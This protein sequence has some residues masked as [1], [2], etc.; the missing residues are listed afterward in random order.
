M[1][2]KMD[3]YE[4]LEQIGKGA[5]GSAI[6]VYHKQERKKYVLKKIRLARQTDRCRRSAHQEMALISKVRHPFII[7]YKESWVEKGCHVCIVTTYCE[8]GDMSEFIKKANGVYFS[9]DRL[10]TWFAQILLAVDY[11]HTNHIL[12]RDLKCSNIFLSK[13]H[14][15]R[16]GDFG[17]A[18]MLKADDLA[19]SVVGTPT[20]MCPELLADIPYGFKS[21][22]WS[23]GCCLFEMAAHKPAFKAFDMQGLV[24]KVNK[25]MIGPLPSMYSGTFKNLVKTMLRKNP[26]HRPTASELLKNPHV[27]PYVAKCRLQ[28]GLILAETPERALRNF[29][30]DDEIIDISHDTSLFSSDRESY[31]ASVK[32]SLKK[33]HDYGDAKVTILRRENIEDNNGSDSQ[34]WHLSDVEAP[35]TAAYVPT[36]GAPN[37]KANAA[38]WMED[39]DSYYAA[40]NRRKLA[41]NPMNNKGAGIGKINVKPSQAT[42]SRAQKGS[43]VTTPRTPETAGAYR[44]RSDSSK[45]V[46]QDHTSNYQL[47][48]QSPRIRIQSK[49]LHED[50]EDSTILAKHKSSIPSTPTSRRAA[51]PLPSNPITVARRSTSPVNARHTHAASSPRNTTPRKASLPPHK[52]NY[53]TYQATQETEKSSAHGKLNV[54]SSK[55]PNSLGNHQPNIQ[56]R[57]LDSPR[58][59]RIPES[60]KKATQRPALIE[61]Q[62]PDVSVNSP[63]LD[64][65]PKF[66][67]STQDTIHEEEV[68][69]S[70]QNYDGNFPPK[71]PRRREAIDSFVLSKASKPNS[72]TPSDATVTSS[73]FNAYFNNKNE[74]QT[75]TEEKGT[76]SMKKKTPGSVR[77]A[78][79][80]VI[81]VIRHSTFQLAGEQKEQKST[82]SRLQSLPRSEGDASSES[83]GFSSKASKEQAVSAT[84]QQIDLHGKKSFS[85]VSPFRQRADALEGLLELSAQLL[86][87]QRLEELTIVLKPFGRGHSSPMETAMWLSKSLKSMLEGPAAFL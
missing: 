5:F 81:H 16:L 74:Q 26:E 3:Q 6:L 29:H 72:D 27:K 34:T 50:S 60:V 40:G 28:S 13:D 71:T 57:Q 61:N 31:S 59:P 44:F 42:G 37:D 15:I 14:G 21:D 12:H 62:S 24:S 46:A 11:L 68:A 32:A 41:E 66:S 64:L 79:N 52:S 67:V 25:S 73:N 87:Q 1:E 80:D 18:K 54:G 2:S 45:M 20:Y 49:A 51:L 58:L 85:D 63:R 55:H 78:Y 10:C 23:L 36:K 35:S 75:K 7:G 82:T 47:T 8:G 43:Y 9:E 4:I 17:L 84:N 30:L 22:I 33:A 19:S 86:Q 69:S 39:V 76:I 70:G 48:G 83:V 56:G 65:I 77:P 53:E 38:A